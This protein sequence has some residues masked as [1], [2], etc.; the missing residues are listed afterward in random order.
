MSKGWMA[1]VFTCD[2]R[3]PPARP[4]FVM[5]ADRESSSTSRTLEAPDRRREGRDGI[6]PLDDEGE[7]A[8]G[9]FV[10]ILDSL[11]CPPLHPLA[12]PSPLDALQAG[13]RVGLEGHAPVHG[14][15]NVR[16]Q[17]SPVNA[18]HRV[19]LGGKDEVSE[20]GPQ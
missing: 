11:A 19:A 9:A 8:S 15:A 13:E 6:G 3:P 7:R 1:I 4:Y 14:R 18:H 16:T 12:E 20:S 2:G 17:G 5:H 10:T